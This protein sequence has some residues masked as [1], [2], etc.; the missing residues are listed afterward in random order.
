MGLRQLLEC[1]RHTLTG[2]AYTWHRKYSW[3]KG[4]ALNL[5]RMF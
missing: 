2:S 1:A 4:T 5:M 3:L